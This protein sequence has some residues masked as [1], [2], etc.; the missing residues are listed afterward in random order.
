MTEL[1]YEDPIICLYAVLDRGSTKPAIPLPETI[2][3]DNRL[4]VFP[5]EHDTGIGNSNKWSMKLPR[6]Y[7][8]NNYDVYCSLG[9]CSLADRKVI[10]REPQLMN[11][12]EVTKGM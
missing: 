4:V 2:D 6:S 9:T 3:L 10:F 7:E 5:S 8:I 12:T 11:A 1:I